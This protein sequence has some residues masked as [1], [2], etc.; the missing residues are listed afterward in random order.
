MSE[1]EECYYNGG[2]WVQEGEWGGYYCSYTPILMPLTNSQAFRLTSVEDGV[3]F[4]VNGDGDLERTSWTEASSKVAFLAIDRNGN[5]TIDNGTELFGN[6]T[7]PGVPNGFLALAQLEPQ[8]TN[9]HHTE[10]GPGWISDRDSIYNKLLLWEDSN[11]N[12]VSEPDELQPLSNRY[13]RIGLGYIEHNRRDGRG[14]SF[15]Y[16]GFAEFRTAQGRNRPKDPGEQF[17]R[18]RDIFDVIFTMQQ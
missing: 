9:D 17:L 1:E 13:S 10:G 11:H 4:D 12:G 8:A 2:N 3:S 5:G 16:K 15:R 14:N 7:I 18:Q 6:R